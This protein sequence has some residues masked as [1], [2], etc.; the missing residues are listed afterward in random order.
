[1]NIHLS[2]EILPNESFDGILEVVNYEL[3]VSTI[4]I[5]SEINDVNC[6]ICEI[7]LEEVILILRASLYRDVQIV[8][9]SLAYSL[10]PHQFRNGLDGVVERYSEVAVHQ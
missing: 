10:V 9:P 7:E 8:K 4:Y 5:D 1:M 3:Y 2:K 6:D